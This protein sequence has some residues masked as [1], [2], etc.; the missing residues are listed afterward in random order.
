MTLHLHLLLWIFSAMTPQ[1]IRD[2][3]MSEDSDFQRRMVEYLE[4]SHHGE[5][6]QGDHRQVEHTVADRES[7]P[8]YSNP[9]ENLPAEPPA[10]C[11]HDPDENCEKCGMRDAWWRNYE[12]TVDDILFKANMHTCRVNRCYPTGG[13]CKAR[14]PRDTF[15]STML[16]PETGALNMKKGESHMNTF[17]YVIAYLLR[18]N[19]DVTSLLSGTA[20]KAVVAYVTEYVTKSGL[21]TYQIFDVIK[22]VFDR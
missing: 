6:I 14:F 22:S 9:M 11:D 5:F 10:L 3:L 15:A 16:D 20:L 4:S 8:D 12:T 19:H 2:R 18:C 17:S 7:L 21:K 13:H 1:E